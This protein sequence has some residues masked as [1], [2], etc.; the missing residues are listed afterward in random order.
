MFVIGVGSS[1]AEGPLRRLAQATGGACEFATP[2][3][4]LETAARRML[5]RIRQQAWTNLRIDWGG[6]AA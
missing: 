2:G 6:E 4:A 3:E 5:A 1:P